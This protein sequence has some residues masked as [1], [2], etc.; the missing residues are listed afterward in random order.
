MRQHA[1]SCRKNT[2][3]RPAFPYIFASALRAAGESMEA[4]PSSCA[5]HSYTVNLLSKSPVG[6]PSGTAC[7]RGALPMCLLEGRHRRRLRLGMGGCF[8]FFVAYESIRCR[9]VACHGS[10]NRS[11]PP[12]PRTAAQPGWPAQEVHVGLDE[13]SVCDRSR[14]ALRF[15]VL[16]CSCP[17]RAVPVGVEGKNNHYLKLIA[18]VD[19]TVR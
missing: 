16:L 14:G 9:H 19:S 11:L 1:N 18:I 6:S 8:A 7:S 4:A 17:I 2:L 13:L 10:A 12:S 15:V 3:L 5:R